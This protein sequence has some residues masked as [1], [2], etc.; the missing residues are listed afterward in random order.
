MNKKNIGLLILTWTIGG[1]LT[2]IIFTSNDNATKAIALALYGL[3]NFETGRRIG[4]K[5]I[6]SS[7]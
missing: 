4:K 3:I 1:I 7:H 5:G 6:L 2:L